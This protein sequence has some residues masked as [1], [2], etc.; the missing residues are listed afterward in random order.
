MLFHTKGKYVV[1][2]NINISKDFVSFIW[3]NNELNPSFN[4]NTKVQLDTRSLCCHVNPLWQT[5]SLKCGLSRPETTSW[6]LSLY[7]GVSWWWARRKHIAITPLCYG[8]VD[9]AL[10]WSRSLPGSMS[11]LGIHDELLQFSS[12]NGGFSFQMSTRHHY[13]RCYF[14]VKCLEVRVNGI[15]EFVFPLLELPQ[16]LTTWISLLAAYLSQL[17]VKRR[18]QFFEPCF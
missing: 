17:V 5:R 16:L 15:V 18:L 2:V 13:Q 7:T 8:C 3:N 12:Q 4:R 6:C 9:V 14:C 1:V 11:N 10:R